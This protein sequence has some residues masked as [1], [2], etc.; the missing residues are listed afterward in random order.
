MKWKILDGKDLSTQRSEKKR[1]QSFDRNIW[2]NGCLCGLVVRVLGRRP[3]GPEFDSLCYQ[4]FWVAM[5][6][7]R[8]PLNLMNINKG[9]LNEKVAAT[10]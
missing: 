8:G 4:I 1:V 5:G 2:K 10:F 3:R 9:Y 6:L 7:E